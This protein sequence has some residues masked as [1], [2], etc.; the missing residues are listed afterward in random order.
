MLQFDDV[1]VLLSQMLQVS[2]MCPHIRGYFILFFTNAVNLC[3]HVIP[4]AIFLVMLVE[5]LCY[6]KIC[7]IEHFVEVRCW[8]VW[9]SWPPILQFTIFYFEYIWH[10]SWDSLH[11]F[12][13]TNNWHFIFC[14]YVTTLSFKDIIT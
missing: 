4:A 2:G 9:P 6:C 12:L 11:L 7:F 5:H 8:K 3:F 13:S 14:S 10:C 1:S